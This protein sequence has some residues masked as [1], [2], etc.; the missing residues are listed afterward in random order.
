MILEEDVKLRLSL[1]QYTAEPDF[2][3][4]EARFYP[5]LA[6]AVLDGADVIILPEY[7]FFCSSNQSAMRKA[8]V[9]LTSPIID[10]ICDFAREHSVVVVVGSVIVITET[11]RRNR[12]LVID[13]EGKVQSVYDKLHLFDV[14]LPAGETYKESA[15][16][17]SGDNPKIC[18]VGD[19]NIGMSIC[20]DL[21]FP[22]LY[23]HYANSGADLVLVPSA[24]ARVTGAAHWYTLLRARAI[25]N[26]LF[27]AAPGL[28]GVTRDGRET[29]GH[30]V[31]YDPWGDCIGSLQETSDCLT[32]DICR[33]RVE[34]V[35]SQIP[36][37]NQD[38]DFI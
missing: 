37:I 31:V 17:D 6:K 4:T 20:F 24:F 27:I 12:S 3:T 34:E 8:A 30:S 1:L 5:L 23:R 33:D 13:T 11:G 35:R 15:I 14:Q 21:R 7:A 2:G 29:Y 22:N 16:F 25:E 32:V 36:I 18:K 19:W 26:G 38:R 10:R 9:E 28:C